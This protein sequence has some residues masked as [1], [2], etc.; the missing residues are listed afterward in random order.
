MNAQPQL[1]KKMS[2]AEICAHFGITRQTLYTWEKK[3]Y[4]PKGIKFGSV[5]RW[6]M[7]EVL[8]FENQQRAAS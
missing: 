3:G 4:F 7:S 6:G 2:I 8:K 5:K 1:D